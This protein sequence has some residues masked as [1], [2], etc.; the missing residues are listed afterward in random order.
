MKQYIKT[1]GQLVE[2]RYVFPG[3]VSDNTIPTDGGMEFDSITSLYIKPTGSSVVWLSAN[4]SSAID[5]GEQIGDILWFY[6][7]VNLGDDYLLCNGQSYDIVKYPK[8]YKYLGSSNMPNLNA[9]VNNNPTYLRGAGENPNFNGGHT[10]SVLKEY[11]GGTRGE[12]YHNMN[13]LHS[14]HFTN[15]S[16]YHQV[17]RTYDYVTG[18]LGYSSAADHYQTDTNYQNNNVTDNKK[19]SVSGSTSETD[20]TSTVT[21]RNPTQISGG[22]PVTNM[23]GAG[24]PTSVYGVYYMRAK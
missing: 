3:Q 10:P 11:N 22:N 18:Y 15:G 12:H 14:H 21:I 8:L 23:S 7:P 17:V 13:L 24:Q 19:I 9:T 2:D 16:H 1:N 6:K 20:M 5:S 4:R